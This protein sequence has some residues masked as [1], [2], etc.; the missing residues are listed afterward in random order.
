MAT[1]QSESEEDQAF[2]RRVRAAREAKFSGQKPVYEFLQIPQDQYKHYE[3][4]TGKG[5]P[6]PRR[7]IPKF[8]TITEVS[9][10]WLL[11]GEGRGPAVRDVPV[12]EAPK[13]RSRRPKA[14]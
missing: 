8:C 1:K 11:T 3:I 2:I 7:Y 9:M 12:Q 13:R 10:E 14:A 5:R 6:L 4:I